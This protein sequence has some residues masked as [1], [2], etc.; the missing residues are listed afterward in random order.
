M[1]GRAPAK[2]GAVISS[3]PSRYSAEILSA[4][5]ILREN[6][7]AFERDVNQ[8]V[9]NEVSL[10]RFVC[11]TTL[12]AD[13]EYVPLDIDVYILRV[14]ARQCH[15]ATEFLDMLVDLVWRNHSRMVRTDTA[16]MFFAHRPC[17]QEAVQQFIEI[18]TDIGEIIVTPISLGKIRHK[19]S[20]LSVYSVSL[21]GCKAGVVYLGGFAIRYLV[22]FVLLIL[23]DQAR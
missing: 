7:V 10:P 13:E 2:I 15:L 5:I 19:C 23:A 22:P 8:F 6:N 17:A 18:A 20:S 16:P 3:I 9:A 11:H 4:S 14:N 21:T 1:R 12:S